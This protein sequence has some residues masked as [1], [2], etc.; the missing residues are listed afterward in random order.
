MTFITSNVTQFTLD[1]TKPLKS[2]AGRAVGLICKHGIAFWGEE[3]RAGGA[4]PFAKNAAEAFSHAQ[5]R[6]LKAGEDPTAQKLGTII[7]LRQK[8]ERSAD[9]KA[10]ESIV[11]TVNSMGKAG[12]VYAAQISHYALRMA[13]A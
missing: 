12:R 9:P 7:S 13:V 2:E 8:F 6:T 11:E 3:V 1:P 10:L 4:N 5:I